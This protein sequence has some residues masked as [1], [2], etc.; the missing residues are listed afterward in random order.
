MEVLILFLISAVVFNYVHELGHLAAARLAGV[1]VNQMYYG[2]GPILHTSSGRDGME[3]LVGLIPVASVRFDPKSYDSATP[4]RRLLAA[5]GGPLANFGCTFLLFACAY[6][7][8][9]PPPAAVLDVV[10]ENGIAATAGL[11]DGDQIIAIDG[12]DTETWRDV[13]LGLLARAGDT[14]T[15]DLRVLRHDEVL[16]FAIPIERWQSDAVW[17]NAFASLGITRATTAEEEE[18]GNPL[19]AVGMA[20]VDSVELGFSTAANG[21]RM[22][23]GTISVLN[24]GGG[25]QLTQLGLDPANLDVG[26][27]L[28]LLGLFSLAFGIINL[29]PGPVV[30]GLAM[31]TAAAEGIAR[32]P[33]PESARKW[34]FAVGTIL[35]FGPIPLVIVHDLLR[36]AF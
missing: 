16:D 34:V 35:A 9:S 7:A 29:L 22:L 28:M 11:H 33:I 1:R 8:F 26:A 19:A 5:S 2:V 12:S 21:F 17:I 36:F 14:G 31:V 23:F 18:R 30:D 10:D 15:I 32:R 4:W 3:S 25:L 6:L 24:F 27:Y 13:G 20:L